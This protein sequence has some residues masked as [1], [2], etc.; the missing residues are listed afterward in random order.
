MEKLQIAIEQARQRREGKGADPKPKSSGSAPADAKGRT[1]R[2]AGPR[3]LPDKLMDRWLALEEFQ[4]P[5]PTGDSRRLVAHQAGAES[6]QFDILRT[7]ILIELRK[8]G[9][10]RIAITSPTSGCGKTTTACNLAVALSRQSDLRISLFDLDLRRPAVSH[11]LGAKPERDI[12]EFL[13]GQ[14]G[15]AEQA[16]RAGSNLA[17]SMALQPQADPTRL[18]A[19]EQAA[20]MIEEVEREYAPDVM[21]FDLPPL[22]STDDA[23]SF[24][25]NVDCAILMAR[26][27]HSTAQ[28]IDVCEREIAEQTNVMGVVLNE[29]RFDENRQTTGEYY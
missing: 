22:L 8:N 27:N 11:I 26:A 23:R 16:K 14:V 20:E 25:R 4:L 13:T 28:Q 1:E 15:Y 5:R 24:L 29:C 3:L 17:A 9:W 10:R 7:K 18:L 6:A 19:S 21:I 12:S 2:R